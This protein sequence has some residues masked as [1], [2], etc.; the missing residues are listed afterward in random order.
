MKAMDRIISITIALAVLAAAAGCG[1]GSGE[2]PTPSPTPSITQT[3]APTPTATETEELNWCEQS[4]NDM[5]LAVDAYYADHGRWPTGDGQPGDIDWDCLVPDYIDSIPYT[6]SNCD[7]G[8][9]DDP[10]GNMCVGPRI[11]CLCRCPCS[12]RCS[13]Y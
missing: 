7:W 12:K 11:G 3:P 8:V 13:Y 5:Q 6:D 4:R 10:L 1:A 9:S 2:A